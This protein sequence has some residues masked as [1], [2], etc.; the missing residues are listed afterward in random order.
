MT[1]LNA[2]HKIDTTRLA[3]NP[4]D[5]V[6]LKRL[7]ETRAV[8][9][10]ITAEL[11]ELDQQIP[12]LLREL[13]STLTEITG[14]GVVT[15]MA[16]LTEVGDPTRFATE[17]QFARWCGAA[18]VAASSGE[19]HHAPRRHRLDRGGNRQVNS[20]LHI[21]HVTQARMYEPA[22]AYLARRLNEG[23]TVREA[24]RCHKRQLANLLIRH[25]WK[26]ATNLAAEPLRRLPA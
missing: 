21:I 9:L 13:G 5:H 4:A 17:A 24:R 14:V 1:C 25:M 11:R 7:V 23:K 16:L 12:A 10:R 15:A 3:L 19:G 2:V 22:R 18:P 6:K 20:V 26:D 8:I